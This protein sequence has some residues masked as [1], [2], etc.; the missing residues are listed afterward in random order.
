MSNRAISAD[1]GRPKGMGDHD[2]GRR[3]SHE[4]YFSSL[5]YSDRKS[6]WMNSGEM[7]RFFHR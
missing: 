5:L 7:A 4:K 6:Y 2:F 3:E 1:L